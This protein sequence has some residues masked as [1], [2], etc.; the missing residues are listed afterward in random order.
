[1]RIRVMIRPLKRPTS[2]PLSRPPST[3]GPIGK[4]LRPYQTGDYPGQRVVEP[5]DRSTPAVINTIVSPIADIPTS[6]SVL[7]MVNMLLHLEEIGR[8]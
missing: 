5:T 8:K 2:N 3:A 6:A 7:L 4:I 1:M